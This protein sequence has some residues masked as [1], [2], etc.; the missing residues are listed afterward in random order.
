[1]KKLLP[2]LL[3]VF[4]LAG[5]IG[6]GALMKPA[7]EPEEVAAC[8]GTECD[9][10][11]DLKPPKAPVAYD[12]E[13]VWDYV[14]LSKQFVVPVIRQEKVRA[15][16]VLTMSLEVEPG[17]SDAALSKTPRLRDA[18][19]Q[20]LFNHANSGGFDGAFTSGR[21]MHDLREELREAARMHLGNTVE[22]VLIEEIVKQSV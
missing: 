21:A 9:V 18:F 12:P 15:L 13:V 4:G 19:L 17:T 20:V 5:G 1:M 3:A 6:A 16:V 14:K 7:P 2:I 10:V 11:P 22:S 8:E